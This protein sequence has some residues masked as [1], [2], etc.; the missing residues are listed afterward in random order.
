MVKDS[1]VI[2]P[3]SQL[4]VVQDVS[5]L[6]TGAKA[7]LDRNYGPVVSQNP[8]NFL[9][10]LN[11]FM[12]INMTLLFHDDQ[13]HMLKY[14]VRGLPDDLDYDPTVGVIYGTPDSASTQKVEIAA[15]DGV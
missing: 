9:S 3:D 5:F 6:Q 7:K 15:T 13:E 12:M 8:G 1:K 14:A 11:S 10:P 2:S 4:T